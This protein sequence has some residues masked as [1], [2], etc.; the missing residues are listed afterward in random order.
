MAFHHVAV[1]FDLEYTAWEGSMERAW[2]GPDEDPEIIQ[3]GAVEICFEDDRWVMGREF[4][5]YVRPVRRPVLSNYIKQ[6]TG[7]RQEIIDSHSV[8][9]S[10]AI[11]SFFKFAPENA[12]LCANGNDWEVLE[13]NCSINQATNPF[14]KQQYVNVRPFIAQMLH[15]DEDSE[16]VYSS[17][18]LQSI[19]APATAQH[20]ALMDARSVAQ[21]LMYFQWKR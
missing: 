6:L 20:N 10:C 2:H 5:E 17:S 11:Q 16:Q 19:K 12:Q 21:F 14:K 9:F 4:N 7:I 13:L 15:R 1:I 3:I 18:L 8:S